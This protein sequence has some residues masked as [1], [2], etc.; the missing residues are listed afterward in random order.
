VVSNPLV[1]DGA[2][3][4][5]R[6]VHAPVGERT[7]FVL[8]ALADDEGPPLERLVGQAVA[9]EER[10]AE[11]GLDL[12]SHAADHRVVEGTSRQP[13]TRSPLGGDD[14]LDRHHGLGRLVGLARQEGDARGVVALGGEAEGDDVAEVAVGNLQQDAGAVTGVRLGSRCAR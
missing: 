6:E 5:R 9:G 12:A 4:E 3:R 13:S 14:L 7:Q 8:H 2:T 10:L 11:D 1:D